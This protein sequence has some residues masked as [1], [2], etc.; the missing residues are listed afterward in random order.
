MEKISYPWDIFGENTGI[1]HHFLLLR[2]FL[3][4]ELNT[5]LLNLLPWQSDSYLCATWEAP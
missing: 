1:A 2:I 4:Q 5:C 3:T